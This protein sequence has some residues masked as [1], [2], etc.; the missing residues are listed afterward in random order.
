MQANHDVLMMIGEGGIGAFGPAVDGHYVPD[1][2]IRLLAQGRYHR[3]VKSLIAS[4]V[5]F[6]VR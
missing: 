3:E 2:P 4:S 5:G 6:E 1:I